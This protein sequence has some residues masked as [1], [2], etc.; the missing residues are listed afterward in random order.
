MRIQ[1]RVAIVTGCGRE[2]GIGKAIA[3][4][5]AKDGAH[6]VAGEYGRSMSEYP[7]AK[8]GQMD[9][10]ESLAAEIRKLG[11][12]CL[13]VKVDVTDEAEVAAMVD[14]AWKEFG[15]IDILCNNAGGGV[16][17]G[18]VVQQTLDAWNKTVA[19]NLTGTFLCAKHVAPKIIQGGRGGR[20][21]NTASIAGKRG[22]PG[23]AA[24]C[25]AKHGVI[26]LTRSLALELGQFGITVNAVCPGFVETQLFEGLLQMVSD[27]QS[28]DREGARKFFERQVP[29]GRMETGDDVANVVAFL[30]S[31]DGN[32]MTGQALNIC[33]GVEWH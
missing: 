5:L 15:R 10:L 12:K 19:I 29:M 25:A 13:P 7:D 11:R 24:Y 3:M 17:G 6:I 31:D 32:Y 2:R 33:G 30:A 8:F 22:G 16:G 9:E 27:T 21:I 20:I 18:P 1:D 26:G 4:R 23:M 14:A 28:T